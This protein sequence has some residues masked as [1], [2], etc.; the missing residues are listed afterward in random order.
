MCSFPR[1]HFREAF[2]RI[3]SKQKRP[4][5]YQENKMGLYLPRVLIVTAW[6]LTFFLGLSEAEKDCVAHML[7]TAGIGQQKAQTYSKAMASFRVHPNDLKTAS[8][9]ALRL[10]GIV[11][12]KDR[13]MIISCFS[14]SVN[15]SMR[16]ASCVGFNACDEFSTCITHSSAPYFVCRAEVCAGHPCLNGGTCRGTRI[17]FTCDCAIGFAGR[18]CEEKYLT[19]ELELAR[20]DNAVNSINRNSEFFIDQ[21]LHNMSA[22]TARL[23]TLH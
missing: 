16:P 23:D 4:W 9:L 14:S 5:N 20:L 21:V 12:K 15:D 10:I 8:T 19:K 2:F 11:E 13:K 1:T 3:V 17:T 18:H 6:C 7:R 22:L